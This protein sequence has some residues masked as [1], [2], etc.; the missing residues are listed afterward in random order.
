[1]CLHL[2]NGLTVL[3][4][5]AMSGSVELVTW[6]VEEHQLNV[7]K[8]D[9]VSVLLLILK[10]KCVVTSFHVHGMVNL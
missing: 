10:V 3:H 5:A 4:H 2:Q 9:K 1:M 6:L 8:W 7:H